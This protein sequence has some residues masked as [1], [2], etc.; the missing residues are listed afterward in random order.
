MATSQH[1]Y[2]EH[3]A[4][5]QSMRQQYDNMLA[6]TAGASDASR[7]PPHSGIHAH[8]SPL[9]PPPMTWAMPAEGHEAPASMLAG[10][11]LGDEA[12]DAPV[13]RGFGGEDFSANGCSPTG[14][15]FEDDEFSRPVYRGGLQLDTEGESFD[16]TYDERPV[17]RSLSADLA[18]EA[19]QMSA[20]EANRR[21]LQ[22]NP[23]MIHRQNARGA[24]L[25]IDLAGL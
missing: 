4:W 12:F 24:S 3:V 8:A 23:P 5:V 9:P 21:W 7:A 15:T 1:H 16:F 6:Q 22:T 11:E 19:A 2:D 25:A 18:P 13:Y 10:M 14:A 17:Y 20:E